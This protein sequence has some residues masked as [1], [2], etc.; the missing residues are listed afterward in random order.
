LDNFCTALE[1][2]NILIVGSGGR[3]YSIGYA[4]KNDKNVSKIYFAP[5]NGAYVT[6]IG[7]NIDIKDYEKL[8]QFA[9]R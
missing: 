6:C 4:L 1:F 2:L 3:E 9:T 5:G 8:A 7:E